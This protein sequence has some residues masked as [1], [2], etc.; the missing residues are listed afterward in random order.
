MSKLSFLFCVIFCSIFC[1]FF[2]S[3]SEESQVQPTVSG[4]AFCFHWR[5]KCWPFGEGS[6]FSIPSL[7]TM[8]SAKPFLSPSLLKGTVHTCPTHSHYTEQGLMQGQLRMNGF[9]RGGCVHLGDP[10]PPLLAVGY[11]WEPFL[12]KQ[13]H[14]LTLCSDQLSVS[15]VCVCAVFSLGVWRY[16]LLFI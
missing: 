13:Q 5:Q 14:T 1:F 6:L 12:W 15:L 8:T 9:S 16:K 2:T 11:F 4:F 10:A 3:T 7:C